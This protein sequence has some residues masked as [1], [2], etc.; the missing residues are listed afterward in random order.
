M[1]RETA[2]GPVLSGC[3]QKRLLLVCLL[4]TAR[5]SGLDLVFFISSSSAFSVRWRWRDRLKRR[6]REGR[7]G[8]CDLHV[9][10][11]GHGLRILH[12]AGDG[13]RWP[14][15]VAVVGPAPASERE[16]DSRKMSVSDVRHRRNQETQ[17]MLVMATA[18]TELSVSTYAC[19]WFC[20][21][22]KKKTSFV[23]HA[24]TTQGNRKA[25]LLYTS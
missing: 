1:S 25:S 18:N 13:P 15:G 21:Q 17:N 14:A 11:V 10:V 6:E 24:A 5:K 12:R 19:R 7:T 9:H 16:H 2:G 23:R 20:N 22:Q 8:E 4:K 3:G